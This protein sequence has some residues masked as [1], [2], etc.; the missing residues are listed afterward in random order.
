MRKRFE[1]VHACMY[2][3]ISNMVFEIDF[4]PYIW[5]IKQ[6]CHRWHRMIVGWFNQGEIK[7][8]I[9]RQFH[10]IYMCSSTYRAMSTIRKKSGHLLTI[11]LPSSQHNTQQLINKKN[12][13]KSLK[14]LAWISFKIRINIHTTTKKKKFSSANT[15]R[16][17]F[18][19]ITVDV[20]KN[21]NKQYVNIKTMSF[22]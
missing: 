14:E 12:I 10:S 21:K 2:L 20:S 6:A 16:Y 4:P 5:E 18:S 3:P 1:H 17:E 22:T 11:Y 19:K 9:L 7:Q 13:F 15:T 8:L